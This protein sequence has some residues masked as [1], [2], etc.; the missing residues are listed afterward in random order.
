MSQLPAVAEA[1]MWNSS[2]EADPGPAVGQAIPAALV[3]ALGVGRSWL[4][5]GYPTFS[6]GFGFMV[7][8]VRVGDL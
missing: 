1:E 4:P 5:T 2:Q 6:E 8:W 7:Q 3:C